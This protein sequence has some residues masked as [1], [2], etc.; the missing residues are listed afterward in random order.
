MRL[1]FLLAAFCASAATADNAVPY[2]TFTLDNGLTLI[3]HEDHKAPI[4]CV[5]VWYHVGSKNERTG[6][7]GLAHLFEHLMFNGS[8]HF[9]DDYFKAA[10]KVGATE[11]N[12][13]TSRDRTNYFQNAPKDALDY[14]L[15]LESDR[16]GFTLDVLD[17]A[18]LDEQRGVVMNEKRQGDNQ[19]YSIAQRLVTENIWPQG[20]PYSWPVIGSMED[21]E[22]ATLDDAKAWFKE[23]YGAANATLVVAGDVV[24]QE[25]Y[26]KVRRAFGNLPPGPPVAR[27]KQ[28]I[29]KR[30]GTHR[31]YAEDRVP[32]AR[33]YQAWNVPPYGTRDGTHLEMLA[34][35]LADGQNSRLY[36]RLVRNE[37][38]ATTVWAYAYLC[39][40][41]GSFHI[42]ATAAPGVSPATLEAAINEEL[43][44]LLADGPDQQELTRIKAKADADFIRS[45]ERIGGFGGKSDMLAMNSVFLGNP[46]YYQT[47]QQD[48]QDATAADLKTVANAWLSDGSYVLEI[49]P[50]PDH[51]VTGE[52]VD[53]NA[54]PVPDIQPTV[55]FPTVQRAQL[56]NGLKLLLAQRTGV[57]LVK[58]TLQA[59][60]GFMRDPEGQSGT[61]KLTMSLLNDGTPRLDAQAFEDALT[62]LGASVSAG[63]ALETSTLSLSALKKNL[64]ASLALYAE[65]I[66]EPAFAETDFQRRKEQSLAAIRREMRE[67]S[68]LAMRVLPELLYGKSHPYARPLTGSGTE[69]GIGQL[70]RDTC[71]E[72]YRRWVHPGNAT[73][74]IVGDVTLEELQPKL[75]AAL[76]DWTGTGTTAPPI[77]TAPAT[78]PTV[79][80]IDRPDSIQ[81]AIVAGNLTPPRGTLDVLACSVMNQALG[82]TF[83]SRINMNLREDKNWTYNARTTIYPARGQ[84]PFY[85]S[86]QVQ[87]DKTADALAELLRELQDISAARPLSETEFETN[88]RNQ[89]LT[90]PGR[91]ETIDNVAASLCDLITFN[92]PDDYFQTLPQRYATL[93]RDEAAATAGKVI[94]PGALTWV[95]VGDRAKIEPAIR[96]LNPGT[97]IIAPPQ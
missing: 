57:P 26:E 66:R 34:T 74:I 45:L 21:I 31:Q 90:L 2:T 86:V 91:W 16:M 41:A 22:A 61:A 56:K 94:T 81:S 25:V 73:L 59:D 11:L 19:P 50:V 18:R 92:R 28:W 76:A 89:T 79:V 64:D 58:M 51:S 87:T 77:P 62:L 70:T 96:A 97:I 72:F 63:C 37:R 46:D 23:F 80:I 20:H 68:T 67:P 65:L 53:R 95:I 38:I 9:N 14:F 60:A 4:V 15:W 29:A 84:Q 78:G 3:V 49:H 71:A 35:L 88:R 36:A 44:R 24:P 5:N 27:Q 82:G 69:D 43:A 42:G 6:R 83:T 52:D 8:G 1:P 30:S 10:E 54:L 13:T 12:G 39:E 7:T 40:I 17:Q 32:H 33:L 93:T 48:I 47:R 55:T 85:A 75:E